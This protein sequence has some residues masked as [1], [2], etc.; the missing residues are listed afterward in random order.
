MEKQLPYHHLTDQE[1]LELFYTKQDNDLLGYL[2]Q[3]YTLLL[4]GVCMKYLKDEETAKDGVQQI[5]LKAL[6]QVPRFKISFFKSWIYMVAKNHC[7]MYLRNHHKHI[8]LELEEHFVQQV[9]D[10]NGIREKL[11]KEKLLEL[12][13]EGMATLGS[14]QKQC[15]TLFYLD[16]KSY[17]E[18]SQNTGL[19]LLQ[20]KSFIQNGKRN[21]KVWVEKRIDSNR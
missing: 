6:Q 19:S 21:I 2:L 15:V 20:V 3:R 4:F 13:E 1:L 11:E 14:E 16:K 8:P 9:P 10:E 7:L 12:I 17:Q 18:I 5:F